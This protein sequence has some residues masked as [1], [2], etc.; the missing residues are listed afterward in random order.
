M[1]GEPRLLMAAVLVAL[2]AFLAIDLTRAARRAALQGGGTAAAASVAGELGE[3]EARAG[4]TEAPAPPRAVPEVLPA[5]PPFLPPRPA[6]APRAVSRSSLPGRID[7]LLLHPSLNKA[8][9][10]VAVLSVSSGATLYQRNAGRALI[11]ASNTKLLTTAAALVLLGPAH[12]FETLL[13]GEGELDAAGTLHG[14]LIVKGAGDPDFLAPDRPWEEHL[15]PRL[16]AAARAAGLKA[17][18]GR[19]IVDDLVLDRQYV[20]PGWNQEKLGDSYQSPVAGLSLY[21]NCLTVLVE[22]AGEEG[23]PAAVRLVPES[24]VFS[25]RANVRTAGPGSHHLI[26][27]PAPVKPG[28]V[29]VTG[30]TPHGATPWPVTVPV[31]EPARVAGLMLR[32]ALRRAG[33]ALAGDVVLAEF[34]YDPAAGGLVRLGAARA[35]LA[36]ALIEMN[37]TSSNVI[38]EHVYKLCGHARELRGTFASGAGAVL[39]VLERFGI[40]RG[41]AASADGSG[42]SRGNRYAPSQIARLLA[43]LYRSELRPAVLDSL[44]EAGVDGTLQRRLDDEAYRGR[45]RAKSGYIASVSALS[46]YAQADHG[47]VLCFSILFNEYGGRNAEMKRVQDDVVKL[48]VDLEAP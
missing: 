20:A 24:S 2:A 12:C 8:A 4:R 26:H 43:A 33:I 7:E 10:G 18:T 27:V 39:A 15:L 44:A 23:L 37:K 13:L 45:V 32:D 5:V 1:R 29:S 16:V 38:A 25:P 31:A 40:E 36:A 28:Q 35:P 9:V 48:L 46:G 30:S 41:E 34:P 47:E 19:L 6:G 11:V 22:P 3:A 17:V 14:D 42:L 21:Q